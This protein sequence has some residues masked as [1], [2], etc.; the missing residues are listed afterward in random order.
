M[1]KDIK[2]DIYVGIVRIIDSVEYYDNNRHVRYSGPVIGPRPIIQLNNFWY[3][4][5]TRTKY[6]EQGS[7]LVDPD[8]Y[9]IDTEEFNIVKFSDFCEQAQDIKKRKDVVRI[10]AK[11][12]PTNYHKLLKTKK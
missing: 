10:L 4:F 11:N 7:I 12:L 6:G 2:D 5:E 1:K 9:Y 3:D 8:G